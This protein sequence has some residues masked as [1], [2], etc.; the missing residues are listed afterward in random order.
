MVKQTQTICRLLP[1]NCLSVFDHFVG[2]ALK[3]LRIIKALE[4][5]CKSLFQRF[6]NKY[7]ESSTD[8]CN[9]LISGNELI[10]LLF[11]EFEIE[12]KKCEKLLCVK[13]GSKCT[14]YSLIWMC[15]NR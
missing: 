5:A 14:Y 15:H 2:L 10:T 13:F 9:V 8:N 4:E 7:L 3:R 6:E 12:N 1:A 11:G